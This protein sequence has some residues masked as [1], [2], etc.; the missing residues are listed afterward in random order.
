M[1]SRT[2]FKK[3][4]MQLKSTCVS[5]S[6]GASSYQNTPCQSTS[7]VSSAD[8]WVTSVP[9][10]T[11]TAALHPVVSKVELCS[12]P[13]NSVGIFA[14]CSISCTIDLISPLFLF[15]YAY[16]LDVFLR[17]SLA[18]SLYVSDCTTDRDYP[19]S[20]YLSETLFIVE[21][22]P[23]HLIIILPS[24]TLCVS[25]MTSIYLTQFIM[26]MPPTTKS[27]IDDLTTSFRR[28]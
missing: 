1:R 9:S 10:V 23:H 20:C 18:Q 13:R 17:T 3:T 24:C 22:A 15:P 28:Y 2:I 12:L 27:Q 8:T 7:D 11:T 6:M 19:L 16:I 25:P 26:N 14:E 21:N 5:T 4:Q